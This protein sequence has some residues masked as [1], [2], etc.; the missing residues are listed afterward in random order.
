MPFSIAGRYCLGIDSPNR[1]A[2]GCSGRKVPEFDQDD[3]REVLLRNYRIVYRI[4]A[5]EI[6][7]LTVFEGHRLLPQ[8]VLNLDD[9][10]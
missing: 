7:V 3:V 5:T 4:H 6:R 10:D 9:L 1:S 8:D 2:S